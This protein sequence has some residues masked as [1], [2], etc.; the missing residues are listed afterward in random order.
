[1]ARRLS[2]VEVHGLDVQPEMLALCR[3]NIARNHFEDRITPWQGDIAAP[4]SEVKAIRFDQIVTNPPFYRPDRSRGSPNAE[5]D[6]A[7]RE[8][9]L[10]LAGWID[11]CLKR[12]KDGGEISIVHTADR[13]SDILSALADR[14]GDVRIFPL[15]PKRGAAAHRVIVK[16]R[17]GRK[18]APRL[19]P[20]LIVHEADGAQTEAARAVLQDGGPLS[21]DQG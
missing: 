14:T 7:H 4:P 11:A 13:L 9:T 8:L 10:D 19:L 2:D 16:A 6:L 17:K 15:W 20:G 3:Q 1:M 12:L 5:K 18:G 21:F